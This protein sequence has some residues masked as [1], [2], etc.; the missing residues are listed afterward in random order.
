MT[1]NIFQIDN[2]ESRRAPPDFVHASDELQEFCHKRE[3]LIRN[4]ETLHKV[5]TG[6]LDSL[7][8]EIDE[9]KARKIDL[10]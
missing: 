1:T 7:D 10:R 3:I 4:M 5:S 6:I 9:L 2:A 8:A